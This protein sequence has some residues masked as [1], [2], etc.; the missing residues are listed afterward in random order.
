LSKTTTSRRSG[1]RTFTFAS[2]RAVRPSE[3]TRIAA[4]ISRS[5]ASSTSS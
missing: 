4:R 3:T 5:S 2:P 1:V